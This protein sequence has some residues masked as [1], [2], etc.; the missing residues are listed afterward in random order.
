MARKRRNYSEAKVRMEI[1]LVTDS[2]FQ[3]AWLKDFRM[4]REKRAVWRCN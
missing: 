4:G 1:L 2:E 3:K